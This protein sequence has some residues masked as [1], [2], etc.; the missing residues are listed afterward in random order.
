MLP[1]LRPSQHALIGPR[2]EPE[3]ADHLS[4]PRFKVTLWEPG[5]RRGDVIRWGK[6]IASL[7]TFQVLSVHPMKGAQGVWKAELGR[8]LPPVT[9]S[10]RTYQMPSHGHLVEVEDLTPAR[11]AP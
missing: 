7:A 10:G 3:R 11:M 4:R 1:A 2:L 5:I 8:V 6:D 9:V